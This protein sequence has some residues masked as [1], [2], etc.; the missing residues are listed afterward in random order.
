[1]ADLAVV[2]ADDNPTIAQAVAHT[3]A[4]S[5]RSITVRAVVH[6]GRA[7]IKAIAREYPDIVFLDIRMPYH[8]G[9]SVAEFVHRRAPE[10]R[11]VILTAY[12]QFDYAR[13][14]IQYGV[15]AFLTKPIDHVELKETTIELAMQC[16]RAA[17]HLERHMERDAGL[18]RSRAAEATAT[19]RVSMLH[20][21]FAR[22]G[23]TVLRAPKDRDFVPVCAVAYRPLCPASEATRR[24]LCTRLSELVDS[25]VPGVLV[26]D[27]VGP[28]LLCTT[29]PRERDLPRKPAW[30]MGIAV[31][32]PHGSAPEDVLLRARQRAIEAF[33]DV[34]PPT[35]AGRNG[36]GT[37][38]GVL[39]TIAKESEMN[40]DRLRAECIGAIRA[41]AEGFRDSSVMATLTTVQV[42]ALVE[43]LRNACSFSRL[44]DAFVHAFDA[45]VPS[46][47]TVRP[48]LHSPNVAAAIRWVDAHLADT[49]TLGRCA[50][51]LRL[52]ERQVRR[53]LKAELGVTFTDLVTRMRLRRALLLLRT[54]TMSVAEVA[55][56][57]GF[58]SYA[59]FYQVF[60]TVVGAA[61][62]T[63]R[64]PESLLNLPDID[65][66]LPLIPPL[67]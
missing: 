28:I 15:R 64:R 47:V 17:I 59:Y 45:A 21:L 54:T 30:G 29:H 37:A 13:R 9:L 52:S 57:T 35:N 24:S 19:A 3:V 41:R 62:R 56:A 6:D 38:A 11:I 61:P 43:P 67:H 10:T 27:G 60:R 5:D 53:S 26:D 55:A 63:F 2:V 65:M 32:D 50:S 16:R 4:A 34:P 12:A 49:I 39:A 66:V 42:D 48:N 33:F 58:S 44:R 7:A 51:A 20:E 31:A 18:V 8:D 22:V 25:G 46:T 23:L 40:L 1:M 36:A 14:A